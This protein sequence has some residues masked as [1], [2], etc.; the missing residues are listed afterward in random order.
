MPTDLRTRL[1]PA[2]FW[3][4]HANPKS[5]WS[6]LATLPLIVYAIHE[7]RWRLLSLVLAFTVVNPVLFPPPRDADAWMTKAVLAE[8]YWLENDADLGVLHLLNVANVPVTLYAL[9]AAYR[10]NTGEATVATLLAMTMKM[11]FV[12]ALVRRF[13]GELDALDTS[14]VVN[15][16]SATSAEATTAD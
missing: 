3:E 15:G 4:R 5:G 14:I 1:L 7:R 9:Y 6:R 8:R 10:R 13:E 2:T 16:D 12:A 11:A